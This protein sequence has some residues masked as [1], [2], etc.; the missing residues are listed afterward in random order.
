[1][2]HR[3]SVRFFCFC[4]LI[5]LLHIDVKRDFLSMTASA[6]VLLMI[7]LCAL[8]ETFHAVCLV[9]ACLAV[10]VCGCTVCLSA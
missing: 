4:F 2:R 9:C 8:S 1:M 5:M 10:T 3:F 7:S 6:A